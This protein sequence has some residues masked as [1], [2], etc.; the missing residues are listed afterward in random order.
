MSEPLHRVRAHAA[1]ALGDVGPLR[2]LAQMEED[3]GGA[4]IASAG[5]HDL[6]AFA[7]R[8]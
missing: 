8:G 1:I 3:A 4:L 6:I 7:E 2:V 5:E